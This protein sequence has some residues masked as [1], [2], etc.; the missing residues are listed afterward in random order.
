M[1][2]SKL[3][4]ILI[5][6][7]TRRVVRAEASFSPASPPTRNFN[8]FPAGKLSSSE[9]TDDEEEARYLQ[10]VAEADAEDEDYIDRNREIT[11]YVEA[12]LIL[13]RERV[14]SDEREA[15]RLLETPP[16]TPLPIIRKKRECTPPH[17]LK[18]LADARQKP[19]TLRR[20]K[21]ENF[22]RSN[23]SR[24]REHYSANVKTEPLD[25]YNDQYA[26]NKGFWLSANEITSVHQ[27]GN[28]TFYPENY[29][30]EK[31]NNPETWEQIYDRFY[32]HP[33]PRRST[34]APPTRRRR[35]SASRAESR[36]AT[37]S[38]DQPRLP[39]STITRPLSSVPAYNPHDDEQWLTGY[40]SGSHFNR[41]NNLALRDQPSYPLGK[42]HQRRYSE[43][44]VNTRPQ[45][46]RHQNGTLAE[47]APHAQ[48]RDNARRRLRIQ[49]HPWRPTHGGERRVTHRP[50]CMAGRHNE[51]AH[52]TNQ[53]TDYR[54]PEDILEAKIDDVGNQVKL[55]RK[56]LHDLRNKNAARWKYPF[57]EGGMPMHW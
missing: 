57:Y 15:R 12:E 41:H 13:A 24:D 9:G 56:E 8:E 14:E 18:P 38:V 28:R 40:P 27:I 47:G 33:K 36:S 11:E 2:V 7:D 4:Y 21:S 26:E 54:S 55:L 17:P 34:R 37:T 31:E 43:P 49:E 5:D 42:C 1:L 19:K 23:R 32:T 29:Q 52:P 44:D 51:T 6:P 30:G 22:D 46:P 20:P 35:I 3:Y 50:W 45:S 25:S 48:N 16:E 39:T 10:A 53:N